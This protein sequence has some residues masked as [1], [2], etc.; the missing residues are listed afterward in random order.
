[1]CVCVHICIYACVCVCGACVFVG[2]HLDISKGA[3]LRLPTPLSDHFRVLVCV[4]ALCIETVFATI[5][6]HSYSFFQAAAQLK[7]GHAQRDSTIRSHSRSLW[8]VY[9]HM[10]VCVCACILCVWIS[11]LCVCVCVPCV[12]EPSV[13]IHNLAFPLFLLVNPS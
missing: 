11:S 4:C 9:T 3:P 1:M 10:C 7:S 13:W 8:L 2:E 6:L 12:Y 5:I